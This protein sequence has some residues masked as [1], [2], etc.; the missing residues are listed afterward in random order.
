[1]KK[2]AA[3]VLE[4]IDKHIL[5]KIAVP[6]RF[7]FAPVY[8]EGRSPAG[9][10]GARRGGEIGGGGPAGVDGAP[11]RRLTAVLDPRRW[12]VVSAAV[13]EC[14]STGAAVMMRRWLAPPMLRWLSQRW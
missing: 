2:I 3:E 6:F 7:L 11:T 1:M 14:L 5:E 12:W 13:D 10:G 4:K 8:G 9:V